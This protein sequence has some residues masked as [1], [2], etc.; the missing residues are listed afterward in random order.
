MLRRCF[1]EFAVL[2][3]L[4]ERQCLVGRGLDDDVVQAEQ[5][6]GGQPGEKVVASIE[7]VQAWQATTSLRTARTAAYVTA[8]PPVLLGARILR[9]SH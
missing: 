6:A 5:G 3:G 7:R 1:V 9:A 8:S 2:G 4:H